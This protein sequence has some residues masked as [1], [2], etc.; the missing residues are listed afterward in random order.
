M[1]LSRNRI[2]TAS[3]AVF[4]VSVLLYIFFF[5][6]SGE[7]AI[8]SSNQVSDP[9]L[10]PA[11]IAFAD[12][13][14]ANT[15][16]AKARMEL[17]MTYE[18][19][20]M[21][22]FAEATY[23][24]YA[25]QFPDRVIGWYRLAIVQQKQGKIEEAIVSLELGAAV[26]PEKMD[27]P[28]WQLALWYIDNGKLAQAKEQVAIADIKRPNSMQV[29]I[30]KGRIA[31]EEDNPELA[32]Q[33][34]NNSRLIASVPDGYV[35]QLL[36]RAYRANGEEEKSREAWGRGGE[37]KKPNWADPWTQQVVEHVIGLNAM[38]QEI[39]RYMQ[40]NNLYEVR[41]RI[42]EYFIYDKDNRVI[43]RIEA[44]WN[45]KKGNVGVALKKFVKLIEENHTDTV[46]MILL[47]KLR[48]RVEQLQTKEEIAI[49]KEILSTV[50]EITP[51]HE[52]A[53]KLLD[54]LPT[55]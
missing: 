39:M 35:Y 3:I 30:A 29:Q 55:E 20:G 18:G 25:I 38:R 6:A 45:A 21:N 15:N 54:T 47:A 14:D 8:R 52:Q 34:F 50:L 26:A 4:A 7:L 40:A 31:L 24:Q 46:S 37:Q 17:G 10:R 19:A 48:M 53:K 33:I 11:L 28:H 44:S 43:R 41:R 5:N 2:K 22:E 36:G 23:K 13:V 27:A 1:G 12:A 16:N 51:G 32:I 42:D 49:T 9:I